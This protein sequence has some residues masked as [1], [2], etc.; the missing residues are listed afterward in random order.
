[1]LHFSVHGETD[2]L[3]EDTISEFQA[4]F[5]KGLKKFDQYF[6][7][8]LWKLNYSSYFVV[9][10]FHEQMMLLKREGEHIN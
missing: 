7:L 4:L 2:W 6:W 1:M 9:L 10:R 3:L 5:C 8:L